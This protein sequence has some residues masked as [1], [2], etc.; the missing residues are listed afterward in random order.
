VLYPRL[1]KGRMGEK[2]KGELNFRGTRGGR[3]TPNEGQKEAGGGGWGLRNSD[4]CQ[5]V[6]EENER[7]KEGEVRNHGPL[8]VGRRKG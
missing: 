4:K 6:R 7:K 2:K 3:A 1:E 8:V 5:A